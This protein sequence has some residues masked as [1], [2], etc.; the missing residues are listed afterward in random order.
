MKAKTCKERLPG[1]IWQEGRMFY[2]FISGKI[3]KFRHH[4]DALRL[5]KDIALYGIRFFN[6]DYAHKETEAEV[7]GLDAHL[8]IPGDNPWVRGCLTRIRCS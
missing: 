4:S 6:M 1:D 7:H 8:D 5:K 3:I 2:L